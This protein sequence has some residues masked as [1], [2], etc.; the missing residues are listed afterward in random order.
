MASVFELLLN[1]LKD[2]GK[3]ELKAF[4]WHLKKNYKDI[5]DSEMEDADRFKTVDKM[6]DHFGEEE[7]VKN[8]VEILRKMNKNY[9]AKQL[10]DNHKKGNRLKLKLNC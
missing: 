10:E 5:S 6:V 7:A 2:L 4:Q 8:T 3:E 9:L 1:S